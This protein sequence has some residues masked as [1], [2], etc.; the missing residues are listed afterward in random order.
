MWKNSALER[1]FQ[2]V[3]II[4]VPCVYSE[5][6]L[7]RHCSLRTIKAYQYWIKYFIAFKGKQHPSSL[8][9]K[10]IECFL[11]YLAVDRSVSASTQATALDYTF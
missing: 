6:L 9:T 3:V 4:T 1:E 8:G 2:H 10:Q 5:S 7:V 11:T